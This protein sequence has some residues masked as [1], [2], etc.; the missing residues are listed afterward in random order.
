MVKEYL[1]F[2]DVCTHPPKAHRT[3]ILKAAATCETTVT[4]CAFCG[5]HLTKPQTDC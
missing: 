5:K 2:K 4:E 3:V 1:R